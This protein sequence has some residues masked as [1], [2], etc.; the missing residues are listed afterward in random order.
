MGCSL[1]VAHS[2]TDEANAKH[3]SYSKASDFRIRASHQT[4]SCVY[5]LAWGGRCLSNPVKAFPRLVFKFV[6]KPLIW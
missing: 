3:T 4:Q 6:T 1:W 2:E 5:V